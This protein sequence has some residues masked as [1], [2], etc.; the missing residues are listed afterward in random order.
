MAVPDRYSQWS[1]SGPAPSGTP[2]SGWAGGGANRCEER[3]AGLWPGERTIGEDGES[4]VGRRWQPG[5]ALFGRKEE[6]ILNYS[7]LAL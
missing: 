7:Y 2:L 4:I 3:D 6:K 5:S 1:A